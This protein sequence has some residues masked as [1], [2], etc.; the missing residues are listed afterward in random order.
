MKNPF[1]N[2]DNKAKGILVIIHSDLLDFS[3][4]FISVTLLSL[5]SPYIKDKPI[6]KYNVP[7]Q[8]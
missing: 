2:S 4:I 6:N 7:T 1:P 3:L 8:G 5:A